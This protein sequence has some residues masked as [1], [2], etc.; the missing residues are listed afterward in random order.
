MGKRNR[1]SI[2]SCVEKVYGTNYKITESGF[3][4]FF[5]A[6]VLVP[7][8]HPIEEMTNLTVTNDI[9]REAPN[10]CICTS[11]ALQ[12]TTGSIQFLTPIPEFWDK[13]KT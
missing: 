1:G 11:L 13:T 3:L 6:C 12:T 2:L 8:P 7:A 9:N 4:Y 10:G 5:L